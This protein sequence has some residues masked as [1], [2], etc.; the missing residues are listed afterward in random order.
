MRRLF[1]FLLLTLAIVIMPLRSVW[2]NAAVTDADIWLRLRMGQWI[3]QNHALPHNGIFTQHTELP[4]I[5]YTWLFDI[6]TWFVFRLNSNGLASLTVM[7]LVLHALIAALLFVCL[8]KTSQRFI[9]SALLVIV[10]L[11]TANGLSLRSLLL[12]LL[13]YTMEVLLLLRAERDGDSKRLWWLVPIFVLWTNLHIQFVYGLFILGLFAV[14]ITV[15]GVGSKRFASIQS[16]KIRPTS[17]WIVLGVCTLATLVGPYFASVYATVFSYAGNTTQYQQVIEHAAI[18]F[19]KPEHYVQLLLVMSAFFAV[20]WKK[21]LD[22]FRI[23]LL[24]STTLVAFRSQRDGWFVCITAGLLIAEALRVEASNNIEDRKWGWIAP[25]GAF[26]AAVLIAFGVAN[27]QGLDQMSLIRQIDKQ[28]PVRAASFI[29]ENKFPGPL[30]NTFNWGEYLVFNLRDYP[31]S[32][33]GRTDLFG[34]ALDT[35]AMATVNAYD[36]AHDSDFQRARVILL[37]RFLPLAAYL[38]NDPH[39]KLVYSDHIA[40][41][42]TKVQ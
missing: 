3:V 5:A 13:L 1:Q 35:R 12:S 32:I 4:W 33:D 37:E 27:H 40:V 2:Y 9:S 22:P 16:V 7:L 19:R 42:F 36:L 8:Y 25:S 14:A 28:Y 26:C 30:Y 38:A 24:T 29:A 34:A 15:S 11:W 18:N 20:G 23:L 41:V 10:V 17:A 6:L 31:V 21:S 39:Y